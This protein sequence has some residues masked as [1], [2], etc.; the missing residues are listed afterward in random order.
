MRFDVVTIFPEMFAGPLEHSIIGRARE[1]GLLSVHVHD[2]RQWA[3]DKHHVTDDYPYGGGAGMVMKVEPFA[4]A[5]TQ[6]KKDNPGARVAL[7]SPSGALLSQSMA[8]ELSTLPGLIL[9]CGRYEG[10]DHRVVELFC[11]MEISIGDYVLTGGEIP[12]MVTLDCVARLVPGVVKEADSVLYES[13]SAGLLEHPHYTRPPQF[14]E[15]SAPEVLLSG[16]HKKIEMWRREQSIIK[17]ARTRPELLGKA[18]L[19]EDEWKL[20]RRIMEQEQP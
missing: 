7:M 4:G 8:R 10:V 15:S 14:M 6:L 9:L 3:R 20:A 13:H 2:L 1:R 12:A 19:S 18:G 11:D 17:T 16:D 5:V